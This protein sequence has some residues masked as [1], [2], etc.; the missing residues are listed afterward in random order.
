MSKVN[1]SRY[2]KVQHRLSKTK[3]TGTHSKTEGKFDLIEFLNKDISFGNKQLSDKRKEEFY[4]EFSTLLLSGIDI[5]TAFDLILVDQK[6]KKGRSVFEHIKEDVIAG[7]SLSEAI[8]KSN[9]FS[10]YEVYSIKIGEETGKI[11]D[12]LQELALYFKSRISQR[13]KIVSALTYPLIVLLTSFGAVFFMLKFVVPMF[14]DVFKKFGGE[15][16]WVT[17][18]ILNISE[19]IDA[20]FY[21]NKF[22]F[23]FKLVIRSK[24]NRR[25]TITKSYYKRN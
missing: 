14:A 11:G 9:K 16:P 17:Q 13:R 23:C 12:I 19:L 6:N 18:F 2:K 5:R 21:F 10:S 8:Y 15:L 1:I 7:F 4:L 24:F 25:K 20:K 22:N 3:P